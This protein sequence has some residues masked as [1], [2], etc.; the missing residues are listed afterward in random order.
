MK[1]ALNNFA[2]CNSGKEPERII[3]FRDVKF[4]EFLRFFLLKGSGQ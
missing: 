4:L 3:V 2:A 1:N